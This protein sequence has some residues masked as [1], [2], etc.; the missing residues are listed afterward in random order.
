MGRKKG[1]NRTGTEQHSIYP[2]MTV[3]RRENGPNWSMYSTQSRASCGF[4]NRFNY[5]MALCCRG[6]GL[7]LTCRFSRGRGSLSTSCTCPL[8]WGYTRSHVLQ[9]TYHLVHLLSVQFNDILLYLDWVSFMP[10]SA[11]IIII[12]SSICGFNPVWIC[13]SFCKVRIQR[14]FPHEVKNN[15]RTDFGLT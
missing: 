9:G 2:V 8:R 4:T 15:S 1:G 14:W 12:T 11:I 5:N 10:Q 7:L 3:K 6:D 13:L